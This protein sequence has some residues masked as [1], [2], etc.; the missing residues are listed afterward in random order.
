MILD[1]VP[2]LFDGIKL[3]TIG[4]QHEDMDAFGDF[5][6]ATVFWMKTSS[7]PYHHVFMIWILQFYLL[8]ERFGPI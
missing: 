4:W 5:F 8:E 7:I 3:G 6:V 1:Q 2:E